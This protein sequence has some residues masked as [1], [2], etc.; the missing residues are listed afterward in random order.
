MAKKTGLTATKLWQ[1]RVREKTIKY[2]I[3]G[4]SFRDIAEIISNEL[5]R[6]VTHATCWSILKQVISE[7]DKETNE[8]INTYKLAELRKIDHLENE[9]WKAF[10]R[11]QQPIRTMQSKNTPIE[12][13]TPTGRKK[14]NAATIMLKEQTET[15]REGT[16]G[17]KKFLDTVQWCIDKR[18]EVMATMQMPA[19]EAD[20]PGTIT[21]NTTIRQII[22]G[23]RK[24][25]GQAQ[26]II[27]NNE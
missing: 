8:L 22:I 20:Q 16:A 5:S 18:L 14:K 19:A 6:P 13:T 11:S 10:Y 12:Q 1:Q 25:I 23:G 3:E 2:Y 26:T 9:A 21:N 24:L 27:V 4:N 7:W 15:V 17:D